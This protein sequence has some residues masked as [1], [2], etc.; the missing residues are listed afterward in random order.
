MRLT[1]S[2]EF[3]IRIHV[4]VTYNSVDKSMTTFSPYIRIT[5]NIN[6]EFQIRIH[7]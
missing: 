7:L 5:E 2:L 6:C 1:P 4:C 3:Q